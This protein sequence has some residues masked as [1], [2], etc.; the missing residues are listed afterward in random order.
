MAW[1]AKVQTSP[2][3]YLSSFLLLLPFLLHFFFSPE[4]YLFQISDR[5]AQVK[6]P[7]IAGETVLKRNLPF[8]TL[9]S[10]VPFK[11]TFEQLHTRDAKLL[12]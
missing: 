10:I 6:T 1:K 5:K 3:M 8:H 11:Q 2:Q 12:R 4:V 7:L 9:K